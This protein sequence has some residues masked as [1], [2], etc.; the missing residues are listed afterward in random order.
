M[1]SGK[2]NRNIILYCPICVSSEFNFE[3]D[4][5]ETVTC[6]ACN[7]ELEH[8]ELILQ[9]TESIDAHTKQIADEVANDLKK[10]R[11]SVFKRNSFIKVK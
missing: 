5:S 9:N 11:K 7:T 4:D 10:H 8:T 3:S 2:Y 1:Q 6:S